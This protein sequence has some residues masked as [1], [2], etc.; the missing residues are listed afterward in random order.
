MRN[1]D[2]ATC[3]DFAHI[4]RI[5]RKTA[6]ARFRRHAT[7][8]AGT[9]ALTTLLS[10]CADLQTI[11]RRTTLPAVPVETDRGT[12]LNLDS[13]TSLQRGLAIHVDAQQRLVMFGPDGKYCAEPSPDAL[14]AYASS[15]GLGVSA[16]SAGAASV[17][18]ALQSGV[19]SIG[20]RTQSITLMRDALF[21]VCEAYMNKSLSPHSATMLLARSQDLTAV[22][23]AVEQLTGAVAASQVAIGGTS[24]SSAAA[25]LM[26]NQQLLNGARDD[27]KA[28]LAKYEQAEKDRATKEALVQTKKSNLDQADTAYANAHAADST[29]SL[30]ATQSAKNAAI[31]A[32]NEWNT[33]NQL[34]TNLTNEANQQKK[35]YDEAVR[36]RQIIEAN[37]SASMTQATANAS[38]SG[39]FSQQPIQRNQLSEKSTEHIATAV[40]TMVSDVLKKDYT[41]DGCATLLFSNKTGLHESTARLCIEL[42]NAKIE[43]QTQE[44]KTVTIS[45]D[46]NSTIIRKWLRLDPNNRQSLINWINQ[47]KIYITIA[48]LINERYPNERAAAV[49]HFSMPK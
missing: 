29:D 37:K 27:E 13:T 48:E 46:D 14:A 44:I 43:K 21:R 6:L 34:L 5:G 23:V 33:E 9:I 42:L 24:G 35:F 4:D 1:P 31:T 2:A 18:Q 36:V 49:N 19:G 16:P 25:S 32:R 11:G 20:L 28:Q 15:L 26:A 7:A 17:A 45:T 30:P 8:C 10:A 47:N 22:V 39:Q 41:I 38:M 40:S 3:L 12:L